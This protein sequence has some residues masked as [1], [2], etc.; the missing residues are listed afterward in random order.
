MTK[1]QIFYLVSQILSLK[2]WPERASDI[3]KIL[4]K[5]ESDW[6][7]LVHLGS[8]HLV[9]PT[10]YISLKNSGLISRIP[11][12]LSK[13]LTD[14]Y[15]LN[16]NRNRKIIAQAKSINSL[17]SNEN[18]SC[19]FMKG[20]G[21]IFDGLYNDIGERMLY[22]IDILVDDDNLINAT[23]ILLAQGYKTQKGFNT[24]AYPSTMHYPILVNENFPAGV[25]IHRMPVQYHYIN[26]FSAERVFASKKLATKEVAFWVMD[27]AN[28]II[29]NFIHS[30]LMHNG[31]YHAD[32][33]LR[34]L[35]DLLLLG[36]RQNLEKTFDDFHF[37][38]NKSRAYTNLMRSV[39]T[40]TIELKS[41]K[42]TLF[43]A[44]HSLTLRMS[45]KQMALYHLMINFG[46]KYLVLP[47]KTLFSKSARNYVYSRLINKHWYKE[48][49]N[50]Y[51]RKY[52]RMRK[53]K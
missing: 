39:F 15:H 34:Y 5:T 13:Y 38:R 10:T 40:N 27:D 31:H 37:F 6:Q 18:I 42:K 41:Y 32:V 25:E 19:V 16:C 7:R 24:L 26:N 49:I 30:Q 36:Q 46:I 1:R 48:H 14:I 2:F 21:N 45:Q 51:R 28:K 23:E 35:Y 52:C 47:V 43:L 8:N 53:L 12:D 44:R 11:P 3:E 17:L 22:D 50:A 9:L 29:H 4:P 33:S 20:T